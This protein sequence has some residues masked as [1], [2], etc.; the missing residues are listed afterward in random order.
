[1]MLYFLLFALLACSA[2][3][4]GSETALFTFAR[5][6][7]RMA[8][9]KSRTGGDSAILRLLDNPSRLLMTILLG[10]LGVN[11]CFFAF[12]A[13]VVL[14]IEE[15]V[16]VSAS[17]TA[18]LLFLLLVLVF[19]EVLPKTI[20]ASLP[21]FFSRFAAPIL[22]KIQFVIRPASAALEISVT[23]FYRAVGIDS[24][25]KAEIDDAHLQQMVGVTEHYGMIDPFRADVFE[26]II[27]LRGMRLREFCIPR[28]DLKAC[29]IDATVGE[30]LSFSREQQESLVLIKG[31][32]L[33]EAAGYVDAVE[34]LPV[35]KDNDKQIRNYIKPVVFMPELAK[36]DWVLREFLEKEL[37]HVVVVDE[38]GGVSGVATRDAIIQGLLYRIEDAALAVKDDKNPRILSGRQKLRSMGI[39]GE[40]VDFGES[41]TI[42][43]LI[44]SSLERVPKVGEELHLHDRHFIVL[45]ASDRSVEKVALL[46]LPEMNGKA[47]SS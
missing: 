5:D 13:I 44:T 16:S 39:F 3:M 31:D 33:D 40:D 38:Y 19:G 45:E 7:R 1:M 47:E 12:S 37:T 23:A 11:L 30:V 21:E 15:E 17:L 34:L 24:E 25:A 27:K 8:K 2:F 4:A 35:I 14:R 46:P 36:M 28:V 41:V 20:A 43:G 9:E 10:N 29:P 42:G 6:R 18:S 32:S 26:T 22:E